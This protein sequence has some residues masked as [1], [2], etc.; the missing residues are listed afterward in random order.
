MPR[1]RIVAVPPLGEL[2]AGRPHRPLRA[3]LGAVPRSRAPSTAPT[4]T[5][6]AGTPSA[7]WS[8]GTWC[9]CSTTSVPP[10]NGAGSELR[11]L[12]ANNIDTGLGLN[13]MAA[14]LQDKP[15][16]FETDQFMPLIELGEELSGA[17]LRGGLRQRPRAADPRRPRPRLHVPDRRRGGSLQRGPRLRPAAG[18]APRD[19]P[20][21][22]ARARARLH[23]PLR[24]AGERADGRRLPRAAR[25]GRRDRH[26]A[27]GRGAELRADARPGHP[28]ARGGGRAGALRRAPA[29]SRPRS[30]SACTTP[31][32]CPTT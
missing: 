16:V 29:R 17:E 9:S 2:L 8:T 21:T 1:E 6:P 4:A 28:D 26:V 3:L 32:G 13:R 11:P 30:S 31:S 5:A 15:S 18:H 23:G 19:P 22:R 12:P 20:G 24:P 27:R 25:A 14:I 10:Q 7:S